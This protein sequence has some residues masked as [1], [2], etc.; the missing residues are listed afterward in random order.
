MGYA[1]LVLHPFRLMAVDVREAGREDLTDL[2]ELFEAYRV[3]HGRSPAH[4]EARDFLRQRLAGEDSKTY[5]AVRNG[6]TIGFA[7][8]YPAF[9]SLGMKR[10][11]ILSAL[12]I[13]ERQRGYGAGAALL[14]RARKLAADTGAK[15]LV[16][17][18]G[19]EN[20]NAQAVYDATGWRQENA[21]RMYVLDV[22]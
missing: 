2:V 8:L 11:W 9:T 1:E 19:S 3:F 7:Q 20:W 4:D 16:L 6:K 13:D 5:L 14:A 10:Q 18:V 12:F 22:E 17:H 15:G 21:Y